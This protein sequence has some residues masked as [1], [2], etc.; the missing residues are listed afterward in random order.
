MYFLTSM[1]KMFDLITFLYNK[2][3][4]IFRDGRVLFPQVLRPGRGQAHRRGHEEH[5]RQP[6]GEAEE[7]PRHPQ[8]HRALRPRAGGEL[9]PPEG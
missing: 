3:S 9:P 5:A 7:G 1:F 6:R 8:D 2:G 4:G